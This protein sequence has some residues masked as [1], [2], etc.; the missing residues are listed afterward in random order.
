MS[1]ENIEPTHWRATLRAPEAVVSAGYM[2]SA[3][4]DEHG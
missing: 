4:F 2:L 3:R 1:E